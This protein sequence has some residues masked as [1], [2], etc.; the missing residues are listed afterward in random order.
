MIGHFPTP[1]PDELLYSICARFS[2]RVRYPNKEAINTEL[3]G[4][5]G[6]AATIDLPSH[7]K[8]LAS[9][10]PRRNDYSPVQFMN[11]LIDRNTL[12]P[13]YSPF[14]PTKRIRQI[15]QA[16]GSPNGGAIHNIAGTSASM[17][18]GPGWLRFC[19]RC[20]E[21]DRKQFGVCYWHR[22]HHVPGVEVCPLHNLFL[23]NSNARA[24][25]RENTSVYV[26][27]ERA[28]QVAAETCV[29]FDNPDHLALHQIAHDAA[30]L[31]NNP[32]GAS[33]FE[34][35]R[36]RYFMHLSERGFLL[37][38]GVISLTRL[39][40]ALR[41][42]YS[43]SLLSLVQCQFD[44]EKDFNW[45]S[46]IIRHLTQGKT[47][48][49]I[50]HLL[51]I[52]ALGSTVK[53]FFE[54]PL[55]RIALRKSNTIDGPEDAKPF[56]DGP[57]PCLNPVCKQYKNL[58]IGSCSVKRHYADRQRFTG[59]FA[60][61]CGFTY[62]RSGP[63]N[64]PNA[65]YRY[66]GVTHR[67]RVWEGYLRKA[68][69]DSSVSIRGIGLKLMIKWDNV[70]VIATKLRLAFPRQGPTHS[71]SCASAR[72]AKAVNSK[73]KTMSETRTLNRKRWLEARRKNPA[74]NKS[75]LRRETPKSLYEWLFKYDGKWLLAHSPPPFKRI[76]SAR[77]VDWQKRD[78]RI[79]AKISAAALRIR[80]V[81]GPPIRVTRSAISREL[82][83][84]T[85][86]LSRN[87]SNKLPRTLQAID[88]VA[89]TPI[90]FAL[91][92]IDWAAEKLRQEGSAGLFMLRQ[93]AHV[94]HK[95]WYVPEVK[96]AF[97]EALQSLESAKTENQV[98]RAA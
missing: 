12:L 43:D 27:A 16:M 81:P 63:D 39:L 51:L 20:V 40:P 82:D 71:V 95:L 74:A 14:V 4:A 58:K 2:D 67:G 8:Y 9:N 31:L 54:K 34:S 44:E 78:A 53:D 94:D 15:R 48:P 93:R 17:I 7:L 79:A 72:K 59:T 73:P 89:E 57:W 38:E 87:A 70:K 28:M 92:K 65:Q 62:K 75:Q 97:D 29:S 80:N 96:A 3:F 33:D 76:G 24:R 46:L 68:W 60:C 61:A 37:S 66:S 56:G 47:D 19:P 55:K 77:I 23:I 11:R 26:S 25:N 18:R 83:E 52:R 84:A 30:W 1:L 35:L 98:S 6:M 21:D 90:D 32:N 64:S 91:R 5:R 13:L 85:S 45:P 10:L 86:I 50:R 69:D 36:S 49:P 88:K 41:S 22:L 42:K